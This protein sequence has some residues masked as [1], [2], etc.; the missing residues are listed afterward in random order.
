MIKIIE[1][2]DV[3]GKEQTY[4]CVSG[5]TLPKSNLKAIGMW[6][7]CRDC[8]HKIVVEFAEPAPTLALRR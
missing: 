3:C 6:D 1:T 7:M 4:N 8:E 2:C 5:T